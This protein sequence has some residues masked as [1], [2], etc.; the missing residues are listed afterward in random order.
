MKKTPQI[1]LRK[2]LKYKGVETIYKILALPL[3]KF[4]V[5]RMGG[6]QIAAEEVFSRTVL[7]GLIGWNTF[8][9]K[10]T[11]F[12][13]LCKIALNKIADYYRDQINKESKLIAPTLEEWA[14]IKS[15]NLTPE[16]N[17]VLEELKKSVIECLMLLPKEKRRLLY[18]RYWKDMSLKKIADIL[19]TSEKS[20][21]GHL[22]RTRLEFR[23]LYLSKYLEYLPNRRRN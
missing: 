4:V 16:E 5:K 6:D 19:G 18:L 21:E 10:S 12:T 15:N 17:L 3:M 14:N 2:S 13:W 9:H 23:E 22:Y 7:A 8:E 20:V 1:Y 11:Y